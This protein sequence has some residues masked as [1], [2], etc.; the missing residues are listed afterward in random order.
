MHW[1]IILKLFGF[2]ILAA[3]IGFVLYRPV[4]R[5]WHARWGATDEEVQ[6]VLPGDAITAEEVSQTTRI[7]TVR[8]A[9]TQIWPWLLQLGQDRGGM[10][11]YDFLENLASCNIHTLNA[12]DPALQNL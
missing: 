7:I 6:M 5:P 3:M 9:A 10:Y 1:N 12:I 4:I 8:T 2:S 11:S